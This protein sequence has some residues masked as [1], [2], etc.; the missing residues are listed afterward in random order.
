MDELTVL[1]IDAPEQPGT[2]KRP[3]APPA[4]NPNAGPKLR[5][6]ISY[7]R[8]DLDFAD[9]LDAAL[10]LTG[11]DS[12]MDRQGIHGGEEWQSR[13]GNLIRDADTV[14]FVLSSASA[15]SKV[16]SWEVN[17]AAR[18]GKRIIPVCCHPLEGPAPPERLQQLNYIF[19]YPEPKSPGSGFGVGLAKLVTALNT[20]LDW[21]REHTRLLQ[22]A[23]EWEAGGKPAN[24]LLS[25][26][27][28]TAAKAW[29]ARRPKDAPELT[30]LHLDFIRASEL[31]EEARRNTERQ[32]LAEMA[33]AQTERAKALTAAEDALKQAAEAQRRRAA[34]KNTAMAS[35]TCVA[36]LA[37][38][39]W[40]RAEEGRSSISFLLDNARQLIAKVS[41]NYTFNEDEYNLALDLFKKGDALGDPAATYMLAIAYDNGYSVKEDP[42]LAIQ[43]YSKAAAK[44]YPQAVY[45]MAERFTSGNGVAPN[46][47]TARELFEKAAELSDADTLHSIAQRYEKGDGVTLSTTRAR[48]LYE[49]AANRDS[50]DAMRWLADTY[51]NGTGIVKDIKKGREWLEKAANK[52]DVDSIRQLA[53]FYE[54]GSGSYANYEKAREWYEK[55]AQKNDTASMRKLALLYENGNGVEKNDT[56]AREWFEKVVTKE[57]PSSMTDIGVMYENGQGVTKNYVKARQWY[58]AAVD[59]GDTRAM[60]SLAEILAK[61]KDGTPP[62]VEKSIALYERAAA[63][64]DSSAMFNLGLTFAAGNGVPVDG[65]R[66]RTWYLRA[67]EQDDSSAMIN[68]GLLHQYAIGGIQKDETEARKWFDKALEKGHT[69]A[70]ARI[71]ALYE[72]KKEYAE[73][74]TWYDKGAAQDNAWAV[75][76]LA[77]LAYYGYGEPID[78]VRARGLFEKAADLGEV[79]ANTAA[80]IMTR[81]GQG[82]DRNFAKAREWFEKGL[83]KDSATSAANLAWLYVEGQGVERDFAKARELFDRAEE[84]KDPDA[85]F[86]ME[87][88]DIEELR[89]NG[90]LAEAFKRQQDLRARTEAEEIK[91]TGKADYKTASDIETEARLALEMRDFA[92]ALEMADSAAARLE[93]GLAPHLQRAHALMFLG[94]ADE[95]KAIHLARKGQTISGRSYQGWVFCVEEDF[96]RFRKAQ[97]THPLM[98]EIEREFGLK[99]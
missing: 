77:V 47:E 8:V 71:G 66:A 78:Y 13:L 23:S 21:L 83:A 54:S 68:I 97:I 43:L 22:R 74:R 29:A 49:R 67:A 85:K 26:A 12:T 65:T 56:I 27:D 16:C 31:E 91:A 98:D 95:A 17:E 39:Q 51:L 76:N 2:H 18:Q 32:Q 86:Q 37:A 9:Q 10:D 44:N 99:K 93:D 63:L 60:D 84:L 96:A 34:I 90:S 15:A 42:A 75:F 33:A 50:F 45:T 80:G 46:A 25:G 82:F 89:F 5:V 53:D 88:L 92:K 62:D 24:R 38:W 70:P 69:E 14:I 52:G 57:G 36:L 28:I 4:A 30:P 35:V 3:R 61:G 81:Q 41:Q 55:A 48:D 94:R 40:W 79:E 1:P 58:E 19:F 73:A 72:L 59:K 87:R 64:G 20:D 6:F 7:S 11:F